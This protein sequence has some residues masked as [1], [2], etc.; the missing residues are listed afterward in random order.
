MDAFLWLW[1][2]FAIVWFLAAL[3]SKRT[4]RRQTPTGRLLQ[5]GIIALGF[6]LLFQPWNLQPLDVR[7]VPATQAT[8]FCGIAFTAAGIAFA[9][10]ARLTIG[11]NWSG[12]VTLKQDH[13]LIRNGPYRIVRHPIYSGVLLAM[14]GTAI[15][16]GKVPCLIG[17]ALTFAGFWAK[18]RTE[19]QFMIEQFGAQ[20]V[21]YRR[22]VKAII[23]GLL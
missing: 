10:W 1:L 6:F 9:I 3:A 18:W 7:F 15:G 2:V 20:Y 12:T 14:F 21:E 4:L 16:Y 23:P 11:R 19:E 8:T 5:G 17:L 13:Q 22:E